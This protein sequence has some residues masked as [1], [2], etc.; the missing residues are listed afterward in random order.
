MREAGIKVWVL[1]GDKVETAI[2][3]GYSSG[4]IDSNMLQFEVIEND[5]SLIS[6]SLKQADDDLARLNSIL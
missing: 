6:E 1:T 4:L 3:I 2:N 5:H